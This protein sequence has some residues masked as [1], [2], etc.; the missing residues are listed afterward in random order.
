MLDTHA[1]LNFSNPSNCYNPNASPFF[2]PHMRPRT[3][4]LPQADP[5]PMP[6]LAFDAFGLTPRQLQVLS[7]VVQGKSDW[8]MGQILF[9]SEKTVNFHVERAK[10]K[11]NASTRLQAALI[12][13]HLGVIEGP[14][15]PLPATDPFDI[16]RPH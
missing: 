2:P 13:S 5:A 14:R 12:A 1:P 15:Q 7:W 16:H 8:E 4:C 6:R 10:L 9:I 3:I 11:L